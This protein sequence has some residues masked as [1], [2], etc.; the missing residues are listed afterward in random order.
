MVREKK[1]LTKEEEVEREVSEEVE[2]KEEE[3]LKEVAKE[4]SLIERWQPKTALGMKVKNGEIKNI[5]EIIDKGLRIYEP[6]IADALLP[7]LTT[8]F[9]LIGQAKGKFGGGQRRLFKQTQKKTKEGNKPKFS[10]MAVVGDGN[11][12]VGIGLGKSKETLPA[13][14]KAIRRAK[15]NLIKIRRGCGS[16]ECACKELHSIPFVVEGKSGSVIIRLIPAPKG[17]GLCVEKEC[18]KILKA[19]GIKDVFSKTFGQ[20]RTKINLA[21]A[22]FDALKKLIMVKVK[23]KAVEKLGI[24]EGSK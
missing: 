3:T 15:Q 18:Q 9:I 13:R 2:E 14:E 16:W 19:A 7:D 21:L 5:D 23:P 4:P 11:G 22:C 1:K 10:A 24:I 8:D 6:E 20:T 17:T 12:H